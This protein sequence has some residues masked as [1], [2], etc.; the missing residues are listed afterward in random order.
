MVEIYHKFKD[1]PLIVKLYLCI[2]A[3]IILPLIGMGLYMNSQFENLTLNKSSEI[4]L[5]TLKQTR[6]NFDS[7]TVDTNDISVRIL[8]NELVQGYAK[9]EYNK[10]LTYDE[11]YRNISAWLG[12]VVGSKNYYDSISVYSGNEVIFQQ[13]RLASN[14]DQTTLEHVIQLQG[15]GIWV[16][17]PGQI[18][19]YRAI[20]DFNKMG[21]SIGVVRFDI[22]EETL[23]Q[24]FNYIN[25]PSG[26]QVFLL[27]STGLVLSSTE[28]SSIGQ[29]LGYFNYMDRT[30]RLKDGFFT[31]DIND[32]R[33]IVLFY[34]NA[35]TNWT[36]V[37]T[38]PESSFTLLKTT[39]NTILLIVITLC[40]LF[41]ILFSII[42]HKYLLK[43]LLHLRKEMTK[44]KTGNFNIALKIDSKDEIGEIS[45]GFLRMAQQLNETINDVYVTKIKQREAEI[46]AL[47]SQINPHFLYNTLDSIHWLAIK[48]KNYEV[49][50]QIEALAEIFRHVL[51]KGEPFVTIRQEVD[52][53][54]NYMFIQKRKYGNRITLHIHVDSELL[55]YKTPKLIL[56]PLVE[57]A[58]IHGLEQTVEGGMI[59]VQINRIEEGVRFIVNDNGM[60]TDETKI[61]QMMNSVGQAKDVF[62]L[63]N[64]DDRIKISYGQGYGLFFTSKERVGTRV[65]V[66]IPII[67]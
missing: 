45:Q 56:Q 65:E 7:L 54:E 42:Q 20:M 15:K 47:E 18:S 32:T 62:A 17:V 61:H 59:E 64:I 1:F 51:N 31:A 24:C 2:F 22:S 60:G 43:P 25:S 38:I 28:R 67:D 35:E 29:D 26:S 30:L 63:K 8:S 41:G 13:G 23:Y 66:R 40:I 12:D 39:I 49:S 21:R 5:Q 11:I 6:Q 27:D 48:Q 46:T 3:L 57:N 14:M 19:Y 50:E 44:L 58:I 36:L 53:L 10:T 37:Q 34:T 55:N 52:F 9:G 4:A 16:T 33:N